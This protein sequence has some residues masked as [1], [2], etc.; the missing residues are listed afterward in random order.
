MTVPGNAL[1]K[2]LVP[3]VSVADVMESD[4]PLPAAGRGIK[5]L[6]QEVVNGVAYVAVGVGA[7][8]FVFTS[9]WSP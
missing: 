6:G 7:G 5:V 1:A 9:T 2:V 4:K 3:G 8:T